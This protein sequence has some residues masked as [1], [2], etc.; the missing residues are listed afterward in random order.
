MIELSGKRVTVAGLGH[1]GGGVAAARWLVSQGATVTVTDK[2]PADKL[3]DSVA[4]LA[5]LPITYRLGGHEEADF[6]GADLVV[7]SP[8]VPPS[9][10]YLAAARSSGVPVT[11]EICLF[12]ER[13]RAPVV[14][15]TGTKGKSTTAAMLGAILGRQFTTWFGGN[16]GTSLL[17]E[18]P[19]IEPDHVVVLELSSFMLDYLGRAGWSPH[20]A[21]VTLL[22]PDHLDWHGS[23]AVYAAAKR[24]VLR[25]QKPGDV[26][27]VNEESAAVMD[28]VDDRDPRAGGARFVPYGVAGR[29]PFE[30]C[31]P[32]RH[33][34]LN[35]QGAYAAAA[36]LGVSWD[37]AQAAL[38]DFA[39]LPH[40]LQLVHE[41][42]GVRWFNDSIAT[43]PEAAAAALAAFDDGRVIHVVGGSDKGL[44]VTPMVGPLA[45]RAK[46]V[47]C[48]GQT[49]DAVA[50]AVRAAGGR[51]V[52]QCVTLDAAAAAARAIAAPGDV[53]LL[54]PGF[55]SYGQFTN[56]QERGER[57]A[58]LAREG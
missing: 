48:V 55:A 38:R 49:G 22:V 6:A 26:A 29:R 10:P 37:D 31:I 51:D 46:A 34:Q 52:R 57:F 53:V 23:F 35:A 30:L 27:V 2:A 58:A 15:V 9:N 43:V 18:L 14:G 7:A 5:G 50:A 25:Y 24:N 42:D 8:A 33:N 47:L 13:C 56:F 32:G 3:A 21:V 4:Q 1:F 20:V 44:D 16:I 28:W 36:A 19:N 54:S 39:G 12:A 41:A 45:A 17:P 40:R 11:T